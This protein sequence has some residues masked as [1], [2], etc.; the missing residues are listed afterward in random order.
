MGLMDVPLLAALKR[1][2]DWLGQRQSV[3]AENV[4]NADTPGYKPRDL[5]PVGFRELL[6]DSAFRVQPK[7]TQTNHIAVRSDRGPGTARADSK[8]FEVA[9]SGNAVS[10]EDQLAKVAEVQMEYTTVTNIYRKQTGMLRT[11]LGKGQ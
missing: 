3:L 9:P 6:H 8:G 4:A 1:R 2:M 5:V 10:L 11:A 7:V